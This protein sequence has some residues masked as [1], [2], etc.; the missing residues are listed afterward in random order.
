MPPADN[1]LYNQSAD[2][3]T[4]TTELR[5]IASLGRRANGDRYGA[6]IGLNIDAT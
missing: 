4:I 6:D 1:T 5:N 3:G 2:S